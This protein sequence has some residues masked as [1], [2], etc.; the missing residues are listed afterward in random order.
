M[1]TPTP[2]VLLPALRVLRGETRTC[3][4]SA[5]TIVVALFMAPVVGRAAVPLP[6]HLVYGTI[7]LDGRPV[8][9]ANTDVIIEARRTSSGPVLA[10]YRMGTSARLGD[11]YYSLRL[12]VVSTADAAPNQAVLGE[13]IVITV[14][15][16]HGIAYQVLHRVTEPGV[17]LRLDFGAGADTNS[18]GVPDGWEFATLGTTGGNLSNDTDGDGAND[19]SEYFGGTNPRNASDVFRLALQDDGA[20][21]RVSFRALRAGGTGFEGRT[22]YYSLETAPDAAAGPWRALENLSRIPGSDQL[23]VHAQPTGTNAPTFFRARVWLE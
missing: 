21:L 8:T 9:K 7:A 15:A 11:F 10:T 1:K 3:I 13:S 17:A 22:R 4:R 19:R 12:P 6:D 20:L 2:T 23:V 16:A 5:L 18:D 14:R